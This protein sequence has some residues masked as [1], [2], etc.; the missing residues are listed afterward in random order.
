[1]MAGWKRLRAD[2]PKVTAPLLLLRS[3]GGPRGGPVV[4]ADHPEPGLLA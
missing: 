1:M 4:G 3:A 2:L